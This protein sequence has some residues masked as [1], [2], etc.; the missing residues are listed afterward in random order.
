MAKYKITIN[1][2][3]EKKEYIKEGINEWDAYDLADCL[4]DENPF[5]TYTVEKMED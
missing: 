3:Y 1:K 4:I 2:G 5:Y